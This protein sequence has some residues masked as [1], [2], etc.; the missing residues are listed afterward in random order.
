MNLLTVIGISVSL[1]MDAF[2]VSVTS[3]VIIRKPT[4]RQ[5]F[6]LAFHFGLFQFIM[7]VI[8]FYSGVLFEAVIRRYDHWV[9]FFLL[10]FIGGKMFY[11]SF[12]TEDDDSVKKD[13]SKG[14]VLILLAVATSIDAAAI[15]FSF[16]A[17]NIPIL[18][19][20]IMIG[21]IC[22]FFSALGI[23]LGTRIGNTFGKWAERFGGVILCGIGTKILVEHLLAG[24][25]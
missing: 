22:V 10:L 17:L 13:P 19:P 8:G 11:E 6:R 1:A 21:L 5:Y 12:H 9:A 2:S 24:I 7:P 14:R 4:F 3:G 16:A 15:G 23:Y 20:S 25:S 18:L